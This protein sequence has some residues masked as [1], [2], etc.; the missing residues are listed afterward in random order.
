M[1]LDLTTAL[2]VALCGGLG[3]MARYGL[4]RAITAVARR[5]ERRVPGYPWGITAVN[6]S[7]SLALGLLLGLAVDSPAVLTGF[8]GGYTTFSTAS[9]DTL[10]LFR[11][12]RIGAAL[13]NGLGM[14]LGCAVLAAL[15]IIL[16]Q[17]LRG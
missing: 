5:R 4:D 9:L 8:L 11:E 3:A 15:G 2:L 13:L 16:G 10:R 14:L 7:G 17:S 12:R 6:L 1:S